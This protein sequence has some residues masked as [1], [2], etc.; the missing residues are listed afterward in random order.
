MCTTNMTSKKLKFYGTKNSMI[1]M[2]NTSTLA[3]QR[4]NLKKRITNT[5]YTCMCV[6]W[7][8]VKVQKYKREYV[9]QKYSLEREGGEKENR[10][11]FKHGYIFLFEEE[12][13]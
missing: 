1:Y 2:K 8:H 7:E 4:D 9:E 10:R 5:N 3:Q 12:I 6:V 11:H 13:N